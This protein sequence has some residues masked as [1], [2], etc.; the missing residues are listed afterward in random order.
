MEATGVKRIRW[1]VAGI[2]VAIIVPLLSFGFQAGKCVDYANDTGEQSYCTIGPA[3][4]YPGAWV[5][6]LAAFV[7]AA[8]AIRRGIRR[9]NAS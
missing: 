7:F 8:Y 9:R 3:V 5:L 2:I 4:G 1:I 6:T